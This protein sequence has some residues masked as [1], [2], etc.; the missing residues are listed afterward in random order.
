MGQYGLEKSGKGTGIN[1]N[2][3]DEQYLDRQEDQHLNEQR[4]S[5]EAKERT[6]TV[7]WHQDYECLKLLV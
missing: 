3:K 6:I 5:L 2:L 7:V 1:Q 4:Q